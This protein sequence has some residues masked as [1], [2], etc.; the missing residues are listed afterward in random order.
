MPLR[1]TLAVL[2]IMQCTTL[3]S[4]NDYSQ[5]PY[6][7]RHEEYNCLY[8]SQSKGVR[9][10][11]QRNFLSFLE[12]LPGTDP[13]ELDIPDASGTTLQTKAVGGKYIYINIEILQLLELHVNT[14]AQD[15]DRNIASHSQAK[16]LKRAPA[17]PSEYMSF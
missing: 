6:I 1:Q 9:N 7:Q 4:P 16:H 14:N 2:C 15:G 13:K 12:S 10:I 17:R 3:L 8:G 5:K 11:I